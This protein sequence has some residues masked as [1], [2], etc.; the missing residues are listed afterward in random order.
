VAGLQ[1]FAM[2]KLSAV[3]DTL[4]LSKFSWRPPG[5]D[6]HR[7]GRAGSSEEGELECCEVV[8]GLWEQRLKE[9]S[10]SCSSFHL[11][12]CT[13]KVLRVTPSAHCI[14]RANAY[15]SSEMIRLRHKACMVGLESESQIVLHAS[16][17]GFEIAYL[18]IQKCWV[19]C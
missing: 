7:R 11:Y 14:R 4:G 6:G 18:L 13:P 17:I 10:R 15:S 1:V 9:H 2:G 8:T 12:S 3:V 19:V 16:T 5:A